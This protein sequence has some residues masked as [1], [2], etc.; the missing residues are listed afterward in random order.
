MANTEFMVANLEFETIKSNIQTF[1]EGQAVFADYNFTGSNLNSD[2]Y[3]NVFH[4]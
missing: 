3:T 2:S 4:S 1:L